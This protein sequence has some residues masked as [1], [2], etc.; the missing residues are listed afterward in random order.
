MKVYLSY[1]KRHALIVEHA[2]AFW[3][4]YDRQAIRDAVTNTYVEGITD[5]NWLMATTMRL[6]NHY[7]TE[8]AR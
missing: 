5:S 6:I 3:N 1:E 8:Q 4:G 2:W 7:H